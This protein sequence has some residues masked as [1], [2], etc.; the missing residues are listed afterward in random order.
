LN[1]SVFFTAHSLPTRI[2]DEDDPYPEQVHQSAADIARILGGHDIAGRGW[3]VAFQSA[4]RTEDPWIGPELLAEIRR[5]VAGG[6]TS[7]VVCPV[8][9]VSDH[10]EILFD[11]DIEAAGVAR[12]L[13]AAFT[14]TSSLND[15]PRFLGMLADVIRAA[16]ASSAG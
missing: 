4:G 2:I 10:L 8:G 5:V 13:G 12:S 15:D 6:S 16:T 9:F 7:V 14:R 3:G 11:L 1:T